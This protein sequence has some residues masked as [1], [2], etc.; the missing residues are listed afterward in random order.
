MPEIARVRAGDLTVAYRTWG[1]ES[2][3]P[4]I[5]LHG[6]TSSGA[7]WEAVARALASDW[8]VYAPDARGHGR[9]DWPG[10]YSFASMAADVGNFAA[11]LRL[12]RPVLIGHSMGGIAAYRHARAVGDGLAALVLSETPPP[13]PIQRPL[14]PRP[15]GPQSYDY[16]A[17]V[18]VVRQLAEP[19]PGWWD[20]LADIAVPTLVI[21]GGDTSP[22][23]QDLMAAMAERIPNGRFASLPGGHRIPAT[24]PAELAAAVTEFLS[25]TI[26]LGQNK[27]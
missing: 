13:T 19:D 8:R 12:R 16:D 6:L 10:E 9:T 25:T 5:L 22:F 3:P 2:A 24:A 18:A 17:R 1:P 11:A 23:D 21:G 27:T 7:A 26:D 15:D 14:P 20:G 4:L